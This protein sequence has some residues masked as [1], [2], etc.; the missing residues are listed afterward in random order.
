[1]VTPSSNLLLIRQRLAA[2]LE[3]AVT[4]A[5]A[6][7]IVWARDPSG[8]LLSQANQTVALIAFGLPRRLLIANE[9]SPM[10]QQVG[11]IAVSWRW[12][13]G[14]SWATTRDAIDTTV[15]ALRERTMDGGLRLSGDARS[16]RDAVSGGLAATIT[17]DW[18]IVQREQSAGDALAVPGLVTAAAAMQAVRQV[19]ETRV[20]APSPAEGWAGIPT[21]W[22]HLPDLPTAPALPWAGYW[23]DTI[24]AFGSETSGAVETVLGRALV[25]LHSSPDEG[26]A[27]LLPRIE[28]I[29][30]EHNRHSRQ[31]LIGPADIEAQ[32]ATPAATIQTSLRI[33]FRFE[34]ARA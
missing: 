7:R 4:A 12:P 6:Q 22:D 33:P 18:E 5:G 15:A 31:V 14:T 27:V 28:R 21:R 3:P 13:T 2:L 8:S 30:A 19:W 32:V 23:I 29:L 11:T 25:Q 10:I 16:S 1:M 26:D 17:A 34:R 9:G 20:Q 24:D